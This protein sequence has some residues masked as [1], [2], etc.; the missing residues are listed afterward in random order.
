V[1]ERCCQ[2]SF[3]GV[4]KELKMVISGIRT[5]AARIQ[6]TSCHGSRLFIRCIDNRGG[7]L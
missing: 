3:S 4:R 6:T 2:I 1:V 5:E 7:Y